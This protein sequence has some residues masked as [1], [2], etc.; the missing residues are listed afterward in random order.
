MIEIIDNLIK[1]PEERKKYLVFTIKILLTLI[2][3]D[4]LYRFLIGE[5]TLLVPF[6]DGFYQ[7]LYKYLLSGKSLIAL[8]LYFVSY[9]CL[10]IVLPIIITFGLDL[11]KFKKGH[12]V[13]KDMRY[14]RK[15]LEMTNI[16]KYSFDGKIIK[17][18]DFDTFYDL[19][20]KMRK[21]T[22][23][24]AISDFKHSLINEFIQL[25]VSFIL[26][27]FFIFNF[28]NLP[29]SLIIIALGLL[30]I[31]FYYA[32][33]IFHS[34][35]QDEELHLIV[36]YIKAKD[37]VYKFISKRNL[38]VIRPDFLPESSEA[39]LVITKEKKLLIDYYQPIT[40]KQMHEFEK[41]KEKHKIDILLLINC[42]NDRTEIRSQNQIISL[43]FTTTKKIKKM[44]RNYTK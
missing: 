10:F 3:A 20:L 23:Q 41:I 27:Y 25:Y 16:A 43:P 7:D 31:I 2:F 42:T 37:I 6:S 29:L 38:T 12:S 40:S 5:Y 8:F 44:L 11:F 4:F 26:I 19:L 34:F 39:T 22:V 17:G 28:Q 35:M 30:L 18:R 32:I 33:N 14:M 9:I 21:R 1:V 36:R 13:T 24:Q 15:V